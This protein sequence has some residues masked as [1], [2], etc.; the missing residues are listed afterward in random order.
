[1][2][3]VVSFIVLFVSDAS[4]GA[5]SPTAS[6]QKMIVQQLAHG[7]QV[8]L[9]KNQNGKLVCDTEV[10][11]GYPAHRDPFKTSEWKMA[12]ANPLPI[13]VGCTTRTLVFE[14][15]K[16]KPQVLCAEAQ[17][18]INWLSDLAQACGR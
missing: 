8:T 17:P 5:T 12:K 2:K 15:P 16:S 14:S 1:M 4:F 3:Y 10:L 11:K 7:Q 18:V 13:S 9:L 6:W